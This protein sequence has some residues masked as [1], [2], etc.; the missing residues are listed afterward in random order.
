[1]PECGDSLCTPTPIVQHLRDDRAHHAERCESRFLTV[2][3]A[4]PGRWEVSAP[5]VVHPRSFI[6]EERSFKPFES[7]DAKILR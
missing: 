2:G 3:S 6:L 1:M 7:T 4:N 5:C